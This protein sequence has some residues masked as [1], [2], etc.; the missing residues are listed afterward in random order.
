MQP[1]ADPELV[2][3]ARRG[4]ENAF[5][6]LLRPLLEP[7][8]RLAVGMLQDRQLAEDAV[9]EAAVKAWRKLDRLREGADIR[10]WFLGIVAN[11]CRSAR[12]SGWWRVLKVGGRER[13]APAP[14]EAAIQGLDLRQAMKKLSPDQRLVIVLYFY[15][16]LPLDQVA[17]IAG[18]S[19]AA[20]RA[21]LYRGLRQLKADYAITEMP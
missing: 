5:T 19:Y 17:A 6:T 9:Q 20:V 4:D 1:A 14:E 15:L 11:E 7:G 2:R 3:Q 18:A 10:P 13:T 8:F 21:R 12:R 16:D